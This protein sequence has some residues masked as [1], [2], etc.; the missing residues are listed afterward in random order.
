MNAIPKITTRAIRRPRYVHR[1]LL[2]VDRG[3]W[4][5]INLPTLED[6]YR[7]LATATDEFD[8]DE[9][10]RFC[11]TQY[12]LECSEKERFEREYGSNYD[13]EERYR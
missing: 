9:F 3:S 2:G 5:L 7:A 4:V 10:R 1:E 11:W 6:W 13:R 12:D 8:D